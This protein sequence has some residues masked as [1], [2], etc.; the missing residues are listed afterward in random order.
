M[1]DNKYV[2]TETIPDA[3]FSLNAVEEISLEREVRR[4]QKLGNAS[5]GISIPK[6][7]A[8]T[9]GIK[10]GSLLNMIFEENGNIVITPSANDLASSPTACILHADMCPD[11]E[12]IKRT[13]IGCYI[14]GYNTIRVES[15]SEISE[16]QAA[17]V[18]EAVER[19]TGVVVMEQDEKRIVIGCFIS[20]PEFPILSMIRRLFLLSSLIV[21][22][23]L[24][25]VLKSSEISRNSINAME[26]EID[27]LYR[28]ILRLLLLGAKDREMAK[29]I[30]IEDPRHMLG[31]RAIAAALE[32]VGD[33][34]EGLS[35]EIL[36]AGFPRTGRGVYDESIRRIL[37]MFRELSANT[38]KC[39]FEHDLKAASAALDSAL[40]LEEQCVSEL[41]TVNTKI[42][43]QTEHSKS[44]DITGS[45]IF[46]GMKNIIREYEFIVQIMMNRFIENPSHKFPYVEIAK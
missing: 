20:P 12:M 26:M 7:W 6:E 34:S 15:K 37:S 39:L 30:G 5:L 9:K 18:M 11:T 41:K 21:E 29:Q 45:L 1:N 22:R 43:E 10:A 36:A 31:D 17:K 2:R 38:S 35:N 44:A 4:V 23:T 19:L 24:E 25:N 42:K 33:I 13:I 46:S 27:R 40:A 3:C 16:D 8:T 14:A 32:S 28:L